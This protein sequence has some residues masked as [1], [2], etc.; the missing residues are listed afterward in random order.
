MIRHITLDG[1]GVDARLLTDRK[2]LKQWLRVACEAAGAE[3]LETTSAKLKRGMVSVVCLLA[4]AH[5]SIHT[6]PDRGVY[7]ADVCASG[8]IIPE[9]AVNILKSKLGGTVRMRAIERLLET[10]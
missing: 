2:R 7:V 3:V 10:A 8:S 6:Y 9:L 5:A 4:G 1:S